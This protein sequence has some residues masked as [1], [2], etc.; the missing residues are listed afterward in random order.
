MTE[1]GSEVRSFVASDGYPLH[2]RIWPAV[3]EPRGQVVVLHGVQSHGGWYHRLGR[4]LAAAG[5]TASFPDRRGSGA[6][7]RRSGAHPIRTAAQSRPGRVA[8]SSAQRAP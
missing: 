5:Y 4:S 6:N 7:V 1:A 2:V 3:P 8:A